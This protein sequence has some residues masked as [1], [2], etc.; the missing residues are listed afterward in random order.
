MIFRKITSIKNAATFL[1]FLLWSFKFNT[2]LRMVWSQKGFIH[3]STCSAITP[4]QVYITFQHPFLLLPS[5]SIE[6]ELICKMKFSNI[7]INRR[8]QIYWKCI[9]F[10]TFAFVAWIFD[11]SFYKHERKNERNY[12]KTISVYNFR[13]F[14]CWVIFIHLK[15]K[16]KK[17]HN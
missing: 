10:N 12:N 4:F 16:S 3:L 14:P 17:I 15:H 11:I 5:N 8:E 13:D 2:Q 7:T 1:E 6:R 9:D